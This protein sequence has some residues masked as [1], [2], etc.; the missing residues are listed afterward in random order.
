MK[1]FN[2]KDYNKNNILMYICKNGNLILLKHLFDNYNISNINTENNDGNT[3]IDIA[4]EN[5]NYEIVK[6]LYNLFRK[7]I[8]SNIN[9]GYF[10]YL[11]YLGY[12]EGFHLNHQNKNNEDALMIYIRCNKLYIYH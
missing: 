8:I 11:G 10:G 7:P 9:P 3:I 4:I 6:Y 2:I 12:I 5:S 1:M